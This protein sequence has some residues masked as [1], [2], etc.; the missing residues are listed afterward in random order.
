MRPALYSGC[1]QTLHMSELS[2][3]HESRETEVA[4][5]YQ[6]ATIPAEEA[7]DPT[8][9]TFIA[10]LAELIRAKR[11][12]AKCRPKFEEDSDIPQ[13]HRHSRLTESI[14][15]LYLLQGVNYIIALAVLPYLVRVLGMEKFGLV[16]FAQS[17]AQYFTLF[18]DYGFNFTAT[19]A[20]ARNRD[21]SEAIS[22]IFS[23]VLVVKL[24]L[25]ILGVLVMTL[26]VAAVPRLREHSIFFLVAYVAVV[27]NVLF[28][29]WYFQGTE[30]MR[31]ISGIVSLARVLGAVALLLAVH[32][33]SDALLALEIQSASL[34]FGGIL[35]LGTAL[36]MCAIHFVR[37][38]R[39]E[40]VS[41]FVEGWSLFIST[42]AVSLYSNTN[43]FLVGLLCGNLQAGYFSSVEK[44]IRSAQGLIAPFNQAI[45]P[46]V[47][48]LAKRSREAAL[49][50][51]ARVL[52]WTGTT[53]L[54][55]SV[56]L[57]VAAHTI[58]LVF[59]GPAATGTVPVLRWMAFLPF[60]IAVSSVLGSQTMVP[61]GLDR[62]FSRILIVSGAFNLCLGM[63]LIHLFAACG[64]GISVLATE[65]L[66][67]ASMLLT[68]QSHKI[69]I[70][71]FRMSMA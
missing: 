39:R 62:Q 60:L 45:F 71:R 7:A 17:L 34:L 22:R 19:R 35:G 51:N 25:M 24:I 63:A 54:V 12:L 55:C 50:F 43:V 8:A 57:L 66:V 26:A 1:W 38:T 6:Q 21:D 9:P 64:A 27:G 23:T 53:T 47:N 61:F 48:A 28:P 32:R 40:V 65:S 70:W 49:Q 30:Q 18:T 10:A 59:F 20:I 4:R 67:A 16:A 11:K 52:A 15:S 2:E 3:Q 33:P 41:A 56:G 36:R 69:S 31:F 42:A 46:H 5:V 68:L 13:V 44:L 37:P 58:A 14:V 29:T